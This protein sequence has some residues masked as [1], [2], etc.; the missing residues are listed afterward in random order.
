MSDCAPS[1]WLWGSEGEV[2]VFIDNSAGVATAFEAMR[3]VGT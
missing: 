1:D 2:V 3:K